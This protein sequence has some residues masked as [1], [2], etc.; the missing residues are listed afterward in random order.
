MNRLTKMHQNSQYY[1]FQALSELCS[2]MCLSLKE[3]MLTN[4]QTASVPQF[5]SVPFYCTK[6][7]MAITEYT[8]YYQYYE[9]Q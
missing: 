5:G 7:I 8:E 2:I 4:G 3:V 6:F 1:S 9:G